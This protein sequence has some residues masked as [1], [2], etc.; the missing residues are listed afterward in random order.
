[1]ILGLLAWVRK[2]L[3]RSLRFFT[4]GPIRSAV[5]NEMSGVGLQSLER[6]IART[7]ARLKKARDKDDHIE[8]VA[9]T[10]ALDHLLDQLHARN[11]HKH[12][13]EVWLGAWEQ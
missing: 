10:A 1:M 12:E 8:V 3:G 6:Q 7:H 11:R 9:L 13:L 4:G 5:K 2:C